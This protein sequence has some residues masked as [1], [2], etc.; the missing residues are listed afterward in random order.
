MVIY[1]NIY[2][3]L[4]YNIEVIVLYNIYVDGYVLYNIYGYIL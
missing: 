4:L 2:G 3:Y 1:R